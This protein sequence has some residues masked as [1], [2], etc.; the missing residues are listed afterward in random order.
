M[1]HHSL[2]WVFQGLTVYP[3]VQFPSDSIPSGMNGVLVLPP[4][5]MAADL[6][7]SSVG[8]CLGH[9]PSAYF[10]APGSSSTAS[11]TLQAYVG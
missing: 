5:S 7:G 6:P 8:N 1:P 4:C 10:P 3:V 2:W 11:V 9:I